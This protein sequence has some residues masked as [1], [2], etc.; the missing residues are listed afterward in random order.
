M[1]W[2]GGNRWRRPVMQ[3]LGWGFVVLGLAG[4][5]LPILQGVL[6]LLIGLAILGRHSPRM[7]LLRLRLRRRHPEWAARFDEADR[8]ARRLIERIKRKA[9]SGRSGRG[10]E[11]DG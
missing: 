10:T 8:R 1:A 9:G 2:R 7:R 3:A 5:V 11:G 4:L 6:F